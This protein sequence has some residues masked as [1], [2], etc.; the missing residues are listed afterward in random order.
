MRLAQ[1]SPPLFRLNFN[2]RTP[3]GVR[4]GRCR[5]RPFRAQFQS[6]HPIRG[7]TWENVP[8]ALSSNISI[9]APHTGCDFA[10][11]LFPAVSANFN[12]RTPYGVRLYGAVVYTP[13]HLISIHAPHTGCDGS[14]PIGFSGPCQFQSTH[15]IRGAT[16]SLTAARPPTV[17]NFN[18]R[19]PY[20][21]RHG[22]ATP[23]GS[24]PQDF[25]PRTPY[26]V[27]L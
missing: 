14:V 1:A 4:R 15:P 19:T 2:P 18:P 20:G 24:R 13:E 5:R 21:V 23:P 26:G 8:G 6:T 10:A 25:N 7:A 9:H 11:V 12:P 22:T 16:G 17:R 27:R 3:Y